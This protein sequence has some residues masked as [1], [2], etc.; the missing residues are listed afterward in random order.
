MA[1]VSATRDTVADFSRVQANYHFHFVAGFFATLRDVIHR[2]M[3]DEPL[4]LHYICFCELSFPRKR[5]SSL[6]MG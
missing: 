6:L 5:E 3:C 1:T 2:L 4:L